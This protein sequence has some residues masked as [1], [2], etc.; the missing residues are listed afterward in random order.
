MTIKAPS[1]TN[2]DSS[3][4]KLKASR[5]KSR[6]AISGCAGSISWIK[7]AEWCDTAEWT[8]RSLHH[9]TRSH[10]STDVDQLVELLTIQRP[11]PPA[12]EGL[13]PTSPA[14]LFSVS[15]ASS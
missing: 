2:R 12:M 15:L 3:A 10:T 4:S 9:D 5:A 14:L 13:Q 7:R 6:C 8:S 1:I 11:A